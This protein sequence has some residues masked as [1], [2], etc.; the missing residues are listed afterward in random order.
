VTEKR[1]DGDERGRGVTSAAPF[2]PGVAAL[3]EQLDEA[4]WVTE[5]PHAHLVPHIA[6]ACSVLPDVKLLE[7]RLL[8]D[9]VLEVVLDWQPSVDSPTLTYR[10]FG[11]I[12][13]FAESS[14]HVAQRS[15]DD[16]VMYE[17]VTGMLPDQ[18]QFRSHGHLVRF[19]IVGR[20]AP[21]G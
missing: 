5:D 15:V 14:T 2:A 19:R 13:S 9:G 20:P 18:T 1:W 6:R 16:S 11:I 17:V 7:T 8:D 3:Q 12:G 10:V 21:H 4:D